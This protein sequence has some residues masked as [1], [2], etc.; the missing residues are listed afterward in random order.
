MLKPTE[1]LIFELPAE[2]ESRV[3]VLLERLEKSGWKLATAE[4]CTGGLLSCLV[5]D[6]EGL[7]HSLDSGFVVYSDSAKERM[8][9]VPP[10]LIEAHGAVSAEVAEA[11]AK[12]ALHRSVGD[13]AISITG[14]AGSAG[15]HGK[16]GLV[17]L[18]CAV[19]DADLRTAK[20]DNFET[21]RTAVRLA[22]TLKAVD[23]LLA[24]V[25]AN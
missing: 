10:A 9:G 25:P 18:C 8:L 23:M 5:T 13:V 3:H 4:S 2:F 15:A 22:A 7:S 24:V 17:F 6:V 14:Y 1:K 21:G 16:S 19:R 12:G 11:M 20:L